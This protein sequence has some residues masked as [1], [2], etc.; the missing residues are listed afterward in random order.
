MQEISKWLKGNQ[1]FASG[2]ELY[3]RFGKSDFN[4]NLLRGSGPTPFAINKLKILLTQLNEGESCI[5]AEPKVSRAEPVTVCKTKQNEKYLILIK[6]KTDLYTQL[7]Y[8]MGEKHHLPEGDLLKLCA[9][10]ILNLHQKLTECWAMI[11]Y[12][13]A[14]GCFPDEPEPIQYDNKTQIQ[15]LR[16]SISKAK[17]RLKNPKC[18]NR[19][20]TEKLLA[21]NTE[22]MN[23]LMEGAVH[24]S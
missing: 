1:D 19:E 2:L 5:K 11:D 13:Q 21:E 18:R 15:Y 24:V 8:Y 22:R 14:K 9:F 20:S 17:T 4:K 7:N 10:T 23:Q 12:Y 3:M 6:R 16:Q